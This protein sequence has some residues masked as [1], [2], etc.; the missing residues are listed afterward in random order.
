MS[1]WN[2]ADCPFEVDDEYATTTFHE[3]E[4]RAGEAS[5]CDPQSVELAEGW[6]A[7]EADAVAG[8]EVEVAVIVHVP[9]D[10]T[11]C[12]TFELTSMPPSAAFQ[13]AETMNGVTAV[14]G[15]TGGVVGVAVGAGV[16]VGVG[17]GVAVAVGTG[18]R[19]GVGLGVTDADA[20]GEAVAG[21]D[22]ANTPLS[23]K[24]HA[25]AASSA[26]T[27]TP[28]ITQTHQRLR[29]SSISSSA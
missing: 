23:R 25:A 8:P 2:A 19:V 1:T 22:G 9:S 29:R 27:A 20:D 4:V 17:V 10:S 21:A 13:P 16:G 12:G 5:T 24:N 14:T 26:S 18:V 6:A 3:P 7:N 15:G 28:T 11:I